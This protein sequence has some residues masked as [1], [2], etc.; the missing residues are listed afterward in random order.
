MS[1]VQELANEEYEVKIKKAEEEIKNNV[2]KEEEEDT[3]KPEE[4]IDFDIL[5]MESTV[6]GVG[7][8]SDPSANYFC[9]DESLTWMKENTTESYYHQSLYPY[10]IQN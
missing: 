4:W 9:Y 6:P 5:Y 10:Y 8:W 3:Y 2:I 7:N 1:E